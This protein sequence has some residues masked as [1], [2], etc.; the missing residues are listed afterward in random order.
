MTK[1][2]W[3]RIE[4]WIYRIILILLVFP[5]Y[6]WMLGEMHFGFDPFLKTEMGVY[7]TTNFRLRCIFMT[8][9]LISFTS[10]YYLFWAILGKIN[11]L[12]KDERFEMIKERIKPGSMVINELGACHLIVDCVKG[13]AHCLKEGKETSLRLHTLARRLQDKELDFVN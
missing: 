5:T 11:S 8:Y 13:T 10:P 3:I 4:R 12:T 6:L 1:L 7:I 2:V 9:M